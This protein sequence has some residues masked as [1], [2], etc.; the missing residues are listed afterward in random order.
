MSF[1]RIK[2]STSCKEILNTLNSGKEL[3][4]LSKRTADLIL[5][6]ELGLIEGSQAS[7][8]SFI[9]A[10]LSDFGKAYI[11]WNPKLKNPSIWQDKK[12][13]ITTGISLLS[14]TLSIIAILK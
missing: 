2:L 7:D 14:L 1:E 13:W 5:L 9:K 4:A 12:Y 10:M 8:K 6:K 3:T 11:H